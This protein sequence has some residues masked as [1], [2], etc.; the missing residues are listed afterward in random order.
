[1]CSGPERLSGI[2]GAPHRSNGLP[3]EP[4][5]TGRTPRHD[6]ESEAVMTTADLAKMPFQNAAESWLETRR[7]FLAPRTIK[8]YEEYIRTLT[9]FFSEV[10]LPDI[11]PDLIRAYQR[12]RRTTAG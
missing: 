6:P 2:P 3:A 10:K 7:P 11:T 1:M 4:P 8:D 9:K 12:M 5:R